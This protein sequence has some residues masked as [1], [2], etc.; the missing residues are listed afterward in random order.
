MLCEVRKGEIWS[1]EG[2]HQ[3]TRPSKLGSLDMEG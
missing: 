2:V 1:I 3:E